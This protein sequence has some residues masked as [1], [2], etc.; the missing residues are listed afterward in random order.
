MQLIKNTA[1]SYFGIGCPR[2]MAA[3]VLSLIPQRKGLKVEEMTIYK[4]PGS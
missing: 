2:C 1:V 4:Q 3:N